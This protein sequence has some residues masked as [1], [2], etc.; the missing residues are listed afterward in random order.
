MT[1]NFVLGSK[2]V[3]CAC[4]SSNRCIS[5]IEGESFNI[6]TLIGNDIYRLLLSGPYGCYLCP[7]FDGGLAI[8]KASDGRQLVL[9]QFSHEPQTRESL[10]HTIAV[11]NWTRPNRLNSM[12]RNVNIWSSFLW[13]LGGS[14][15]PMVK[16]YLGIYILVQ[17]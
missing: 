3:S 14:D 16:D 11:I 13:S 2:P 1:K 8:Y 17:K 5:Y 9:D 4:S 15:D 7:L 10:S 6:N 12:S